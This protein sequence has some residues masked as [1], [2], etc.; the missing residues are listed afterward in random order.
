MEFKGKK[1]LVLGAGISGIAVAR[2]IQNLKAEV[3]LSDTK[4]KNEI[5]HDL[6]SLTDAGVRLALGPQDECLLKD[7]DYVVLS[8]G[9]SIYSPLVEKAKEQGITVM[10]EIEVA[11]RLCQVPLVAITGTNGKTTTTTLIGEIIKAAGREVVVGGNIGLALSEEVCSVSKDGLVVAEI[12]SF[13]LEG[14]IDFRPHIAA[15]LNLTPDHIDR[16]RS[17]ENYQLMKERIFANQTEDDYVILNYDDLVVRHMA[18]RASSQV[19][20]F[21]SR[22]E[23]P[24]GVYVKDGVIKMRWNGE[25]TTISSINDLGIKGA[26]NVENALVAC[27]A[28]YFLGVKADTIAEVLKNFGGVEHRIEPVLTVRGV[29]YYNDSK[30]TNPESAIKALEAFD[31]NIILIAGGRDKNTDLTEFMTVAKEKLDYLILVGE[32][33]TRFAEAAD[34]HG[35]ENVRLVNDFSSAVELAYSLAQPPQ[36]VLL[37]PA[38]ASYDMFNN[39]EERGKVFKELVHQLQ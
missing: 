1:V 29:P 21:S 11:Y 9:I 13:Q 12:S 22:T 23:L 6:N 24:S 39:Y 19:V 20:F 17:M 35:I 28:A 36:V 37:S 5:K 2:I 38:C 18:D 34:K 7:V 3:I 14:A 8:P 25:T 32:A 26:H 33:K 4:H 15:V 31:G 16:H 30:A 10:S 27:G